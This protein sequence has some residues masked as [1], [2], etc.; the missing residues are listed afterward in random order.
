[1]AKQYDFLKEGDVLSEEFISKLSPEQQEIA[2]QINRR[3]EFK[4]MRTNYNLF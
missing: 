4:V 2:D 1:M 3:T